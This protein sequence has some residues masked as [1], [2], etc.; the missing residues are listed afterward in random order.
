MISLFKKTTITLTLVVTAILAL[1]LAADA[2]LVLTLEDLNLGAGSIQTF[3]G[4]GGVVTTG[5]PVIVGQFL[6]NV[7]G[8]SNAPAGVPND[9]NQATVSITSS[10]TAADKLLVTITDNTF[11][12]TSNVNYTLNDS[13]TST[14]ETVGSSAMIQGMLNSLTSPGVSVSGAVSAPNTLFAG[15]TT[16][17]P[18]VVPGTTLTLGGALTVSVPGGASTNDYNVDVNAVENNPVHGTV[19]A[20]AGLILVLSAGPVLGFWLR[21]RKANAQ[22][23]A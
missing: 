20:P 8:S 6:V 12:V 11:L 7:G 9:V 4:V 3:N 17:T 16:N 13:I 14:H 23:V 2:G 5:G 10:G 15:E 19:P 21:R 18:G 22:P 1:P